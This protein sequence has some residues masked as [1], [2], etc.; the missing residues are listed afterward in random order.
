MLYRLI[1]GTAL[2]TVV[3]CSHLNP[4]YQ[5]DE[6]SEAGQSASPT[7]QEGSDSGPKTSATGTTTSDPTG[8]G[9]SS[10]DPTDTD[11]DCTPAP[12]MLP[13]GK[14]TFLLIADMPVCDGDPCQILNFGGVPDGPIHREPH[15]AHYLVAFDIP[16]Y[17]KIDVEAGIHLALTIEAE[18]KN[19]GF[20]LK[21]V[22]P[23]DW[24][25][26]E[27]MGVPAQD[28]AA[29]EWSV[30]PSSN[31]LPM[32]MPEGGPYDVILDDGDNFPTQ[33]G[34][35]WRGGK[36]P[37]ELA[38]SP[39]TFDRIAGGPPI[40]QLDLTSTMGP[41]QVFTQESNTTPMLLFS[42]C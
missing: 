35:S 40:V 34:L 25:E 30:A 18:E 42:A 3:G 20:E 26:G 6:D 31:W 16:P 29:W 8:S 19:L 13:S 10:G 39:E 27:G 4:D 23:M 38:L 17:D 12:V 1:V 22:Y 7:P 9:D 11:S 37:I 28:N 33:G 5:G 15:M 2:I 24:S 21:Q 14:D 32:G 41:V 36:G